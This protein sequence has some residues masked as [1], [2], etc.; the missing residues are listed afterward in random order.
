M[1]QKELKNWK[2]KSNKIG[3]GDNFD[4]FQTWDD[5]GVILDN[6]DKEIFNIITDDKFLLEL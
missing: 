4:G 2:I 1:N 5:I 6:L 3:I